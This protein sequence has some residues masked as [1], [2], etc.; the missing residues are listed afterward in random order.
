MSIMSL[1]HKSVHGIR[2][3]W[4]VPV[5]QWNP[6]NRLYVCL[7]QPF[8]I[9]VKLNIV[10][11]LTK[12]HVCHFAVLKGVV[13]TSHTPFFFFSLTHTLSLDLC[14]CTV[15]NSP[16]RLVVNIIINQCNFGADLL[17]VAEGRNGF[18]REMPVCGGGPNPLSIYNVISKHSLMELI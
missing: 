1:T 12:V 9:R 17:G 4:T 7:S 5:R 2:A 3:G 15:Q 11:I 6:V 8:F 14:T 18:E 13:M 16:K 10:S